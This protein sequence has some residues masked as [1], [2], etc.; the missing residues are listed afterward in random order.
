MAS[1][2]ASSAPSVDPLEFARSV[3]SHPDSVL[4]HF[5]RGQ[6]RGFILD[7]VFRRMQQHFDRERADGT[8][9]VI[10]W[11]ITGLP[12][13]QA[14]RYDVAIRDG[15]CAVSSKDLVHRPRVT[16]TVGPVDFLKLVTGNASGPRLVLRRRL[17]VKGDLVFAAQV[18]S[19]FRIPSARD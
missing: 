18:P 1:T 11:K 12:K 7:E 8:E 4:A 2:Q 6:M 9:A 15:E 10:R 17:R 16:F 13:G 14:D 3:G 19:L 5:M